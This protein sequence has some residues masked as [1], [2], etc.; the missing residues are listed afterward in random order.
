MCANAWLSIVRGYQAHITS[1]LAYDDQ[2]EMW[3][4]HVEEAHMHCVETAPEL[5]C[6]MSFSAAWMQ[7]VS[8]CLGTDMMC[9]FLA[10]ACCS[11]KMKML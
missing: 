7:G 9:K 1:Q 5:I 8:R 10:L 3:F 2:R 6:D 4:N 11:V